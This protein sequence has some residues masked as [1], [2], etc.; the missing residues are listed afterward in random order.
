MWAVESPH[1]VDPLDSQ[2]HLQQEPPSHTLL[3]GEARSAHPLNLEPKKVPD[4]F[5]FK[6][7]EAT[8]WL[9]LSPPPST[10]FFTLD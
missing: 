5:S 6:R 3:L 4:L 7:E 2:P 1:L 9:E 10:I 8:R